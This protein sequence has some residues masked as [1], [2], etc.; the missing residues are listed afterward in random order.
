M[1]SYQKFSK[2]ARVFGILQL[3]SVL[4]GGINTFVMFRL[5]AVQNIDLYQITDLI[6][7]GI[8]LL[9]RFAGN[10]VLLVGLFLTIGRKKEFHLKGLLITLIIMMITTVISFLVSLYIFPNLYS[11][12]SK[13]LMLIIVSAINF[14][15][16][17]PTIIFT[18]IFFMWGIHL[19]R[20]Y[21][22]FNN[23]G[24]FLVLA[25]EIGRRLIVFVGLI[26]GNIFTYIVIYG[27]IILTVFYFVAWLVAI[28]PLGNLRETDE[29]QLDSHS[30]QDEWTPKYSLE[31]SI[32]EKTPNYGVYC[33]FCGEK[34]DSSSGKYC[35]TCGKLL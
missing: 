2:F 12:L 14:V 3:I 32:L 8:M 1:M 31:S 25:I 22:A 4:V 11:S 5:I 24:F 9:F 17:I 28:V 29:P 7:S 15:F 19:K 18:V 6:L 30:Y 33:K 23:V 35:K 26:P 13:T 16:A 10:V 27:G 21:P 34:Q 20:N